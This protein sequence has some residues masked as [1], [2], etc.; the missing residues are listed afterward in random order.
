MEPVL[1]RC[2]RR[3]VPLRS[4]GKREESRE[5]RVLRKGLVEMELEPGGFKDMKSVAR[6]R[7][8]LSR[9]QACM[10]SSQLTSGAFP[11]ADHRVWVQRASVGKAK[12]MVWGD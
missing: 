5:G 7:A 10:V 3:C 9:G 6:P 1:E 12:R 4:E 2:W 11:Y 8:R